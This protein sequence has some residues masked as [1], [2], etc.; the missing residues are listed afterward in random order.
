MLIS[1]RG[2]LNGPSDQ[3]NH[4]DYILNAVNSGYI[5]EIDVWIQDNK[6]ILGHDYPQYEVDSKFLAN[7]FFVCHAK[8]LPALEY[9]INANLH[10]FWH[11]E[12]DYT[13]TSQGYIWVYPG[14]EVSTNSKCIIVDNK[15]PS[16]KYQCTGI[17]SDYVQLYKTYYI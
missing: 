9:C 10:C 5:V 12:D 14:K 15:P 4:P 2:N 11:Q 7:T 13:I 6:Y 17:C 8:N 16:F 3:E 1:H